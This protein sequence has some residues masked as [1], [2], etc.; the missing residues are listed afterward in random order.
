MGEDCQILVWLPYLWAPF[1]FSKEGPKPCILSTLDFFIPSWFPW[2]TICKDFSMLST[3]T[4]YTRI[5]SKTHF[6][7]GF[8]SQNFPNSFFPV[9][10]NRQMMSESELSLYEECKAQSKTSVRCHLQYSFG[11]RFGYGFQIFFC[12]SRFPTWIFSTSTQ[13]QE[14]SVKFSKIIFFSIS[15]DL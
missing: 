1:T 6:V 10:N 9:T 7:V 12:D 5:W 14:Q 3:Q 4:Y 13:I 11:W 15:N 2:S 8:S